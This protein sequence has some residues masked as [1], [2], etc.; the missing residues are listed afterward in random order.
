MSKKMFTESQVK[1]LLKNPYTKSVS[2]KG[3]TYSD[4]FKLK[5]VTEYEKGKQPR[6]IFEECGF[7]VNILG[8]KRVSSSS[9]RWRA[10]YHKEG[11]SGLRD[12][13]SVSSGI[14]RKK[15]LSSQEKYERLEA[16]YR[17]LE[18]ENELL[19]KIRFA[20]RGLKRKK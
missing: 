14:P 8:M 3:V 7:D 19:K 16:Q 4:E 6:Q 18:A 12:T 20:E 17:L 5:V 13:R 11:E 2:Q 9:D 1:K 10:A 15:E